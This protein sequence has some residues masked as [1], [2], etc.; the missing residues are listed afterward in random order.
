MRQIYRKVIA[1]I[2]GAGPTENDAGLA[3]NAGLAGN[4]GPA[5]GTA[6]LGT[7][8]ATPRLVVPAYFRPDSQPGAWQSLA[9]HAPSV[10]SLILNLANGPGRQLDP[11]L[12][13][14]LAG[15]RRAGIAVV[16]YVDSDFG[17]RPR[18]DAIADVER[19]RLWYDV[20]GV[21]FDRVSAGADKLAHYAALTASARERGARLVIFN[22]GTHPVPGYADH[23]DILGTFEGPWRSYLRMTVPRWTRSRPADQFYHVVHSVPAE[24]IVDVLMLAGRRHAGCAFVTDRSGG[25]PY[26]RLPP[27]LLGG[28]MPQPVW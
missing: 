3:E 15:L 4:V 26:D 9:A 22:H 8:P 7:A 17:Q 2:G 6:A 19:F 20:A 24:Q 14:A 23:A 18:R 5:S 12:S 13:P 25:N 27:A 16:G 1:L 28:D 21:C 10:R 11:S